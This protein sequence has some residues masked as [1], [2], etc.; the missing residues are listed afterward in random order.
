MSV[1]NRDALLKAIAKARAWIQELTEGR[2]ASF[3]EIGSREGKGERYV[4]LLAALAF[5]PPRLIADIADRTFSPITVAGLAKAVPHSWD[6][7]S[8]QSTRAGANAAS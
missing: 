6:A 8:P 5:V 3:R 2:A 4:R 1:E 7:G